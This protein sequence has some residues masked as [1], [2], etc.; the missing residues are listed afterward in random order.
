MVNTGVQYETQGTLLGAV[1]TGLGSQTGQDTV[2]ILVV[3]DQV[4]GLEE[5]GRTVRVVGVVAIL[6]GEEIRPWWGHNE[7]DTHGGTGVVI[8][9]EST[10]SRRVDVV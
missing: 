7:R 5:V 8:V 9:E 10:I 1:D 6:I 2:D 3:G 4:T